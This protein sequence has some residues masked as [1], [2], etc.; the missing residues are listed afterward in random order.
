MKNNFDPHL[1]IYLQMMDEI[2]KNIF[3]KT[4]LPG[5]KIPSVRELALLYS[6]NPNTI[7]KSLIELEREGFLR[8]ERAVGRFVTE[9]QNLINQLR[10]QHAQSKIKDFIQEMYA[11]GYD[12]HDILSTL[13]EELHDQGGS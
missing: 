8:S 12:D 7:Q 3:N 1:P 6:I 10:K 13:K 11:F 4:Y 9:D 5:K 2:K